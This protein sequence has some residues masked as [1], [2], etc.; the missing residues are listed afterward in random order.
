MKPQNAIQIILVL[1]TFGLLTSCSSKNDWDTFGLKGKVRT[2]SAQLYDA[3]SK[4]GVWKPGNKQSFGHTVISFDRYGNYTSLDYMD[5]NGQLTTKEIPKRENGQLVEA[6]YYDGDGAL[7]SRSKVTHL[8]D[9]ETK[10]V[11]YDATGEK[12]SAG[13]FYFRDGRMVKQLL[14]IFSDGEI[15]QELTNEMTYNEEGNLISQKQ[16]DQ[17]GEI[18]FHLRFEY[19]D[20]DDQQNWTKKLQYNAEKEGEPENITI[21]EYEY[22]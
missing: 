21:F 18:V 6:N 5:E 17:N 3:E 1:V 4:F 9:E 2:F 7:I 15:S 14:Q 16:T 10:F 20:P 22:Y 11:G 12:S 19:L 13:T 8:S